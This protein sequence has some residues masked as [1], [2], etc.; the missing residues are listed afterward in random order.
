VGNSVF[1]ECC[2]LASVT[3]DT[4]SQLTTFPDHLFGWCSCLRTLTLPDSVTTIAHSAFW[5]SGVTSIIG[6]DWTIIAGLVVHLAKVFSSRKTPSRIRIP[7]SVREI[8]DRVFS[9]HNSLRDLSFD[10]GILKVGVA[11]FQGCSK[12]EKAAFPASLIAIE[13]NAFHDCVNLRQIT[14]AVGSQLQYIHT[15]A[16]SDCPLNNVVVPASIVEIDPSA[17]SDKIWRSGIRFEGSSLFLIDDNFMRSLDSRVIF[18]CI[19]DASQLLIGSNIEVID[20][21]AFRSRAVSAVLFESGTRLME[22]GWGAFAKCPRLKAFNVPESVEIIG[23]HCFEDCTNM[24]RIEFEGSARLKRISELAF[25]G[26]NLHSITIPASTEEIDGSAFVNCPWITIRVA[27]GCVNFKVEGNFLVTSDGTEIVRYFGLDREPHIGKKVQIL[28]KSCFEG[29]AHI[30]KVRFEVGSKLERIDRAALRGCQS[31]SNIEIP[32]SV[33]IIEESSF[34]GCTELESCLIATDS[35]LVTIGANTFAKC[36]SLRS[37]SI[38]RHIAEIGNK[39]FDECYY[40]YRLMFQS[41][42]SLTRII[43]DRSLDDALNGFGVNVSST[44]LRIEVEVGGKELNLSGWVSL[45]CGEDDLQ[46]TLVRDLK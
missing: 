9:G 1:T 23:A 14:F 40:L 34:E 6:S 43:G 37:F 3:F 27:P 10:E 46:L 33:T 11:V 21:N 16:F 7:G 32:A 12:L 41:S 31:L 29:C 18:R 19:S 5:G 36:T 4:P 13:A 22:I 2:K 42:E 39:C 35:S 20:A 24:E 26:C 45:D 38:P 17:F 44:L 8:G 15:E 25:A 30:D 28:Q